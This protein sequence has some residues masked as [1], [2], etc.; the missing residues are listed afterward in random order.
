M[1]EWF[2]RLGLWGKKLSG[3]GVYSIADQYRYNINQIQ[4]GSLLLVSEEQ[5]TWYEISFDVTVLANDWRLPEAKGDFVGK[6]NLNRGWLTVATVTAVKSPA[7][8]ITSVAM[9]KFRS[10]VVQPQH[11][12]LP[13]YCMPKHWRPGGKEGGLL[14]L[15][16]WRKQG[17]FL[18]FLSNITRGNYYPWRT[19]VKKLTF[20]QWWIQHGTA[21]ATTLLVRRERK[22]NWVLLETLATH[23]I[24]DE[25]HFL[26]NLY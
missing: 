3:H 14:P 18:F 17:F 11:H 21:E 25:S 23:L 22:E 13:C 9:P 4:T 15:Y 24:L 5:T 7:E 26:G 6:E 8:F 2:Q 10:M 16:H 20:K 19:A 12:I 1:T